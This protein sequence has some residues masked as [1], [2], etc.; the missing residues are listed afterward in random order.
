[1]GQP[2][3]PARVLN[4]MAS[5][6]ELDFF[7]KN[8]SPTPVA[9]FK[10][11][12]HQTKKTAI[13][14][15]NST[16]N[17]VLANHANPMLAE[18]CRKFKLGRYK[19]GIN[20][21]FSNTPKST[22]EKEKNS[23]D[24]ALSEKTGHAIRCRINDLLPQNSTSNNAEQSHETVD[25]AEYKQTSSLGKLNRQETDSTIPSNTLQFE[26]IGNV[27]S[28]AASG[29]EDDLEKEGVEDTFS[30]QSERETGES[31]IQFDTQEMWKIIN[32][33]IS[34]SPYDPKKHFNYHY[35][36]QVFSQL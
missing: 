32:A 6:E 33:G 28:T 20:A 2:K 16:I 35:I 34:I 3:P 21:Y 26:D 4:S 14:R 31:Q 23:V 11:F 24:Q 12:N 1:M 22:L 30:A 5:Q 19:E 25:A 18:I 9:F 17:M 13:S 7:I 15:W 27:E 8:K 10:E 29:T 36:H